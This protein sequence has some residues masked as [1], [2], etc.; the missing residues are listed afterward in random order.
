MDTL[1]NFLVEITL[2]TVGGIFAISCFIIK[3]LYN[4]VDTMEVEL[5]NHKVA[6]LEKYATKADLSDTEEHFK[7]FL[8]EIMGPVNRKLESIESYLRTNKV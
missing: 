2:G 4:R 7:E 6:D 5:Q 1:T 3:R 8:R